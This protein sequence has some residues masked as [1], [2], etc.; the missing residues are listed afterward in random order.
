MKIKKKKNL[1]GGGWVGVGGGGP[2]RSWVGGGGGSKVW[3][4]WVM[5]GMGDVNK[6]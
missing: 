5:W 4:R 6:E 1:R 3:G 2:I